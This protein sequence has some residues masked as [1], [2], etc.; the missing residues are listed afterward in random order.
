M[1]EEDLLFNIQPNVVTN[2]FVETIKKYNLKNIALKDLRHLH[3]SILLKENKN[4]ANIILL[5][6][7]R[8]RT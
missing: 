1:Q 8:L 7:Q 6:S 2:I 3:A 4:T 5:I